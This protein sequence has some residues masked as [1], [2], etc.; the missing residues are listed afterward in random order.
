MALVIDFHDD[1]VVAFLH[2]VGHVVVEGGESADMATELPAV[3]IDDCLVVDC[4]EIEDGS[5]ACLRMVVE[6]ALEPDGAL[7]EEEAVVLCVPVTRNVHLLTLV[8]I[9]LDEFCLILRFL[10]A[11]EAVARLVVPVPR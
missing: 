2:D 1:E 3:E 8:E 11:E 5:L 10:V 4:T 7:V 6:A 9:V